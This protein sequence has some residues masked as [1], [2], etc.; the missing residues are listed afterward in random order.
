MAPVVHS[1]QSFSRSVVQSFASDYRKG[2]L[3][4]S[5]SVLRHFKKTRAQREFS[6]QWDKN[7]MNVTEHVKFAVIKV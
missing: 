7:Y 1:A 5:F 3:P 6:R 4:G 2:A